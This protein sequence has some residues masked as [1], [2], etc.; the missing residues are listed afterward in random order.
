[1]LKLL[2]LFLNDILK[3]HIPTWPANIIII[4]VPTTY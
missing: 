3:L 1:M 4:Y 2:Y